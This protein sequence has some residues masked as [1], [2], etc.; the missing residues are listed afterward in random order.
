MTAAAY[1]LM[2]ELRLHAAGTDLAAAQWA[3]C[4]SGS[5]NS[6]PGLIEQFAVL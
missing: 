3:H 2:Q 6:L 4:A 1:M 5:S